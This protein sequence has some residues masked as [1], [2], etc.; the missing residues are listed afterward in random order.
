MC[1]GI[2]SGELLPAGDELLVSCI[3]MILGQRE[4]GF[5]GTNNLLLCFYY[6]SAAARPGSH[7]CT[8]SLLSLGNHE[9]IFSNLLDASSTTCIACEIHCPSK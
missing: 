3:I 4:E 5:A 2:V 1:D 9:G 8:Y 6:D 7:Y